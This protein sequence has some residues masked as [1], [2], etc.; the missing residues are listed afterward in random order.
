MA[1]SRLITRV[2][3]TSW[4]AGAP[5]AAAARSA[6][7]LAEQVAEDVLRIE[8]LTAPAPGEGAALAEAEMER[9]VAAVARIAAGAAEAL[10]TG[11]ARLAFGVD[12]AAVELAALVLVADDL[13]GGIDLGK[14]LLGLRVLVLVWVPGLGELA[15]RLLDLGLAGRASHSQDRVRV[16]HGR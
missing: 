15:E 16:T 2:A 4:P 8:L 14:A 7:G 11:E 6:H 1:S 5:P 13:V 10:E 3:A 9:L 12:L